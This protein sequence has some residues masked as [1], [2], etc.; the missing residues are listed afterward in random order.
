MQQ[1]A[2]EFL[3]WLLS[4]LHDEMR[5]VVNAMPPSRSEKEEDDDGW[6]EVGKKNRSTVVNKVGYRQE[7]ALLVTGR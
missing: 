4:S 5:A 3:T 7:R 2:H 6:S 1:D